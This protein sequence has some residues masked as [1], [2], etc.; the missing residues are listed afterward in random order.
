MDAYSSAVRAE[1]RGNHFNAHRC[2]RRRADRIA[3]DRHGRIVRMERDGVH[4]RLIDLD[5]A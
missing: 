5:P 2:D 3:G 1:N 4:A